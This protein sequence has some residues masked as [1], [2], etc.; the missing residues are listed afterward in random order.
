ME[1]SLRKWI[2]GTDREPR[3][4]AEFDQDLFQGADRERL[5]QIRRQKRLQRRE[6]AATAGPDS[7]E[8]QLNRLTASELKVL[9]QNETLEAIRRAVDGEQRSARIQVI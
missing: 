6:H 7:L 4:G 1:R 2:S 8:H 9:Q 3:I 5:K